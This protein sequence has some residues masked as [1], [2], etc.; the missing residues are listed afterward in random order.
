MKALEDTIAA[1]KAITENEESTTA[2]VASAVTALQEAVKGLTVAD[3]NGNNGAGTQDNNVAGTKDNSGA[4]TKDNNSAG[5]QDNNAAA[6]STS[7]NQD[8]GA[9]EA[10]DNTVKTGDTSK[11]A[12]WYTVAGLSMAGAAGIILVDRKKKK[13]N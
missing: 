11:A 13:F 6:S 1:A 2:D 3:N 12:V 4:G 7:E 5:T 9:V 8:A 10:A